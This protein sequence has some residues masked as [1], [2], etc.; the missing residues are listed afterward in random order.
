[1]SGARTRRI[2]RI[3]EAIPFTEELEEFTKQAHEGASFHTDRDRF[4]RLWYATPIMH[5]RDSGPLEES[6]WVI[7]ANDLMERHPEG[8]EVNSFGHWGFGTYER[9]YVRR[10]DAMAILA[11]QK[12]VAQ[13][14]DY[15]IADEAHYSEL[16]WE[17][18]HQIE[19]QCWST[20][21]ECPCEANT[22][23][24]VGVLSAGIASGDISSSADEWYCE[25]CCEWNDLDDEWRQRARNWDYQRECAELE[26]AG[27]LT[28]SSV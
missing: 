8:M 15:G 23:L 14:A 9:L 5:T 19:T 6:N 17:S 28:I 12:W 10:D 24:C 20:D 11:V 13:L 4:T 27:Q 7:V 16:E 2:A 3:R 22:H 26:A 1:M 21:P 18:N 25:F